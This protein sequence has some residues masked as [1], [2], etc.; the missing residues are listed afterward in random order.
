MVSDGWGQR[1][2]THSSVYCFYLDISAIG[3]ALCGARFLC[4]SAA[5][6]RRAIAATGMICI[7][8]DNSMRT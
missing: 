5:A 8:N 7:Y 3:G 4:A 1:G 2:G 6:E